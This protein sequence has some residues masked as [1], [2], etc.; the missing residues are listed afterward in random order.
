MVLWL[1]SDVAVRNAHTDAGRFVGAP[2]DFE[3]LFALLAID[4]VPKVDG[5]EPRQTG[6]II[7]YY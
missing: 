3:H 1:L 6:P 7:R 2:L 5:H 4:Q